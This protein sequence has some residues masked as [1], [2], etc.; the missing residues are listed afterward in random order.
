MKVILTA[1]V[2]GKGKKGELK[3]VPKGYAY[4]FLLKQ[5]L[6]KE[7]TPSAISELNG[8]TK[9]KEKQD[10]EKLAEAEELKA[11]LEKEKVVVKI[12]AKAG[13]DSRL[14]GSI[15]S[16]QVIVAL[17]KQYGLKLDKRKMDME[18]PIRSLGYTK[19]PIKLHPK[20]TA[21]IKIHVIEEK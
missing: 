14:F 15:P 13:E 7:A 4:N 8:Q 3:E 1:D 21:T 6:A 2:K 11:F 12:K 18:H 10:A 20:V 9:A 17:E 16:K 5:G 19:I